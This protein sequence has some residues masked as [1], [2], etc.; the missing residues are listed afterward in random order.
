MLLLSDQ[1]ISD[2]QSGD[3]TLHCLQMKLEKQS[4]GNSYVIQGPGSIR[5]TPERQ[6]LFTIYDPEAS[7]EASSEEFKSILSRSPG[8]F[9]REELFAFTANDLHG[10]SWKS[11]NVLILGGRSRLF[12]K[13]KVVEDSLFELKSEEK[14]SSANLGDFL[15]ATIFEEID[16]PLRNRPF[17][18]SY[19]HFSLQKEKG[20]VQ[21]NVS[22]TE[23]SFPEH[24]EIRIQ[25]ALR[26]VLGSPIYW[27]V[28]QKRI[29]DIRSITIHARHEQVLKPRIQPPIR[30]IDVNADYWFWRMFYQYLSHIVGHPS[31]TFHPLSRVVGRMLRASAS[32]IEN[33][34]LALCT[35]VEAI[36]GEEVCFRGL[37]VDDQREQIKRA[38]E[39]LKSDNVGEHVPEPLKG[40]EERIA[41]QMNDWLRS[42]ATDSLGP[43]LENRV[44]TED[45]FRAWK[46]LRHRVA[47]GKIPIDEDP[48]SLDEFVRKCNLVAMLLYRLIFYAINYQGEYI[49][50]GVE[51][52]PTETFDITNT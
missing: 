44:I 33:E 17:E 21:L 18:A 29:G 16:V 3:F 1:E 11:E 28:V 51:G 52:W 5:V 27:D 49:D 45:Q 24:F 8:P 42:R 4:E 34:A 9:L 31:H 7:P 20:R 25:E 35:G 37:A 13:G 40:L 19:G 47:H 38:I 2:L 23:V 6:I 36:L 10:R 15:R 50:Y 22:E 32:I 41:K 46:N 43:L 14:E 12:E 48:A 39:F 26:F 30:L